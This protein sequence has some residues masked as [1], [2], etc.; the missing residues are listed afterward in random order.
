MGYPGPGF[1]SLNLLLGRKSACNEEEQR[2]L[3]K[4]LTAGNASVPICLSAREESWAG[5]CETRSLVFIHP[6]GAARETTTSPSSPCPPHKPRRQQLG[7][8]KSSSCTEPLP[9][10]AMAL[11]SEL[12]HPRP[13]CRRLQATTKSNPLAKQAANT[14]TVHRTT[15]LER[16]QELNNNPR[17]VSLAF[18]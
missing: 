5:R 10:L 4:D 12:K 11:G 1:P 14:T 16:Q 8:F 15:P 18:P 7:W 3:L 17:E 6:R 2:R 9:T 13:A